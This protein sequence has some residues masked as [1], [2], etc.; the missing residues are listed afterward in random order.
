VE[1]RENIYAVLMSVTQVLVQY[2]LFELFKHYL[3]L[4]G[5]VIAH[6][7]VENGMRLTESCKQ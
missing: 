7:R 4:H 3:I 5:H 1:V 6:Q 2:Q